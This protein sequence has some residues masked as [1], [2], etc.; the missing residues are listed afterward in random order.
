ML[1]VYRWMPPCPNACRRWHTH[2]TALGADQSHSRGPVVPSISGPN[3][4]ITAY[5]IRGA[6]RRPAIRYKR[7]KISAQLGGKVALSF[8]EH[9]SARFQLARVLD[10]CLVDSRAEGGGEGLGVK[11]L[12][13]RRFRVFASREAAKA[14]GRGEHYTQT[15]PT[16]LYRYTR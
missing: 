6:D 5:W 15:I 1:F 2:Y 9:A 13:Y 3:T 12:R 4:V 8:E 7:T 16:A 10:R 14:P 11:V